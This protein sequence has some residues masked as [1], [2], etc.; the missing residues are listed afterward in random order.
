MWMWR[1]QGERKPAEYHR[2]SGNESTGFSEGQI[3]LTDFGSC[4]A[5]FFAG[6]PLIM[7]FCERLYEPFPF[8]LKV[9]LHQST[10]YSLDSS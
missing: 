7:H 9:H 1:Q 10:I 6:L 8:S 3:M 4:L 5:L 2:Y